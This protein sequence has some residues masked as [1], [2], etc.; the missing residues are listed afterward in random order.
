MSNRPKNKGKASAEGADFAFQEQGQDQ[1]KP[2][3][4]A[5]HLCTIL[6]PLHN[7]PRGKNTWDPKFI[8]IWWF[9]P[10]SAVVLIVLYHVYPLLWDFV[11][12]P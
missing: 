11:F 9:W 2:L 10:A 7:L 4:E 3:T 12:G 5:D 8:R 1:K 6:K